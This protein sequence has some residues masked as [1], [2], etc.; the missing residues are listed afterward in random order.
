[1]RAGAW[2]WAWAWAWACACAAVLTLTPQTTQL[3]I[4][5]TSNQ[6]KLPDNPPWWELFGARLQ[7]MKR[8]CNAILGLY[9]QDPVAWLEPLHP[10]SLVSAATLDELERPPPAPSPRAVEFAAA[11]PAAEA[12][13]HGHGRG[14][15][16]ET[17]KD[18]GNGK[19]R[20]GD[21]AAAAAAAAAGAAAD[22]KPA[23]V[24]KGGRSRSR[25]HSAAS[26]VADSRDRRRR[27]SPS[28]RRSRGGG[29]RRRRSGSRSASR[30]RSRD[31][32]CVSLPGLCFVFCPVSLDPSASNPLPDTNHH[33]INTQAL[34]EASESQP[35]AQPGSGAAQRRWRP[36]A[37]RR[38]RW[39]G[40]GPQGPGPLG[41]GRWLR[42]QQEIERDRQL[43]MVDTRLGPCIK[44]GS[45]KRQAKT[46]QSKEE[47]RQSSV[48]AKG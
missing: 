43:S 14:N 34:Q 11:A 32:R 2:A 5:P 10:R 18:R 3:T 35:V 4:P 6:V 46:T 26:S 39:G 23:P 30:S 12:S 1:M 36:A 20:N 29:R 28:P 8:V 45:G 21:A 47:K 27:R 22:Q 40:K 48:G 37:Q 19:L 9:H 38:W 44:Y 25:S 33:L 24:D 42:Q 7:D 31:R 15:G 17:D 41:W 16:K 13:G